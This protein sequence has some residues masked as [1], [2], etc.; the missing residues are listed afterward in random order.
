VE[1]TK[2]SLLRLCEWGKVSVDHLSYSQRHQISQAVSSWASTA[3]LSDLPLEF[4]GPSG[5]ELSA[6]Q[7]VGVVEVEDCTIEVYPKLDAQFLSSDTLDSW[8]STDMVMGNLLW[9]LEVCGYMDLTEADSAHLA[10]TSVCFYDLFA[11]LMAKNL[12][13]ELSR[14]VQHAY[15]PLEGDLQAVRGRIRLLDQTTRNWNRHDRI[16]CNWDEFSTDIALNRIFKCVCQLLQ[17]RVSNLATAQF[18]E[19]CCTML[20]EAAHIDPELALREA[21]SLR[22]NRSN[23]RFKRCFDMAVKLLAGTGYHLGHGLNDTFVFLLDMNALFETYTEI[24]LQYHLGVPIEV[25]KIVGHLFE[26][27]GRYIQQVPDFIWRTSDYLWIGDAKYKHLAAGQVDA[28]AFDIE[29][30]STANGKATKR[31]DRLL[32]PNDVR[33]LT[34]YAEIL[35]KNNGLTYPPPIAILYPFVGAG[36]FRAS[37]A[38]AWNGS[39][40]WLVPVQVKRLHDLSDAIPRFMANTSLLGRSVH[41]H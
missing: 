15:I 14:G 28:A 41:E 39:P 30:R 2:R 17:S 10:E 13:E 12:R 8:Q 19:S 3:G 16:S 6:R 26:S 32:V 1:E 4:S 34:V 20:S 7:H 23:D 27:P 31:A 5:S 25:Q 33:Q 38:V 18:L 22:W 35:R 40:F 36:T 29:E 11:Y 24:I 21:L 37:E 9:M